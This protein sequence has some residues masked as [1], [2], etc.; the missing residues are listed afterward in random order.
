MNDHPPPNDPERDGAPPPDDDLLDAVGEVAR[1]DDATSPRREL[2]RR[3]VAGDATEEEIAALERE[4]ETSEDARRDLEAFRPLGPEFRERIVEGLPKK[5]AEVTPFPTLDASTPEP[6]RPVSRYWI[7]LAA[8]ALLAVAAGLWWLVGGVPGPSPDFGL[9]AYSPELSGYVSDQRSGDVEP[10]DLPTF[11]MGG[12]FRLVLRPEREAG[13]D[14]DFDLYLA[15]EDGVLQAWTVGYSR[16]AGGA[17][18]IEGALGEELPIE[19]GR[20]TLV[21]VW[22]A[23]G[24]LPEP[25]TLDD[26]ESV[27]A[28]AWRHLAVPFEVIPGEVAYG[29]LP[30]EVE[31]AGCFE[32]LPGPICIAYPELVIWARS[33]PD[34]EIIV[35]IDGEPV[36]DEGVPEDGGWRFR[37]PISEDN[38][39][40]QVDASRGARSGD[41]RLQF[42]HRHN[43]PLLPS[44]LH[45]AHT[46]AYAGDEAR[47]REHLDEY[48]DDSTESR[49]RGIAIGFLAHATS[50]AEER[51]DLLEE[52][53]D[54]HRAAGLPLRLAQDLGTLLHHYVRQRDFVSLRRQLEA[55]EAVEFRELPVRAEASFDYYRGILESDVGNYRDAYR[56]L[57]SAADRTR[58]LGLNRVALP[59]ETKLAEVLHHLGRGTEAAEQLRRVFETPGFDGL[60][61]C[62]RARIYTTRAWL[63]ILAG[64]RLGSPLPYLD[65]ASELASEGDCGDLTR[66]NL[67]LNRAL[68]LAGSGQAWEANRELVESEPLLHAGTT[69][70]RLW[71]SELEGR[72]SLADGRA[73]EALAHFRHMEELAATAFEPEGRWRAT[74]RQAEALDRLGSPE[75]AIELYARAAALLEDQS[76][77]VPLGEGRAAFVADRDASIGRY[78]D[79]LLRNG[80][81]KEALVV[82]RQSRSRAL[83]S[84]RRGH[85][86]A[87]LDGEAQARWD[88]HV[89]RYLA[90]RSEIEHSMQGEW[91]LTSFNRDQIQRQR[92]DRRSQALE[93]LDQ[94]F[95]VF[96]RKVDPNLSSPPPGEVLLA[97]H[98]LPGGW[99]GF[100]ALGSTTSFH[101]FDLEVD[102]EPGLRQW[103]DLLLEPFREILESGESLRILPYGRLRQ[104]DFH[105]LPWKEGALLDAKPVSY[106]LDL[107]PSPTPAAD[108][109]SLRRL[110]A[111]VVGDPRSNLPAARREAKV[112]ERALLDLSRSIDSLV[113]SAA[114][115]FA[116]LETLPRTDLLHFAGHG[117]AEGR[118]GSSLLLAEGSELSAGDVLSLVRAPTW[119]VLSSCEGARDTGTAAPGP[120]LAQAFLL[121]GSRGVVAAMRP[122]G[123]SGTQALFR[124]FYALDVPADS[125]GGPSLSAR[126]RRAQLDWRNE[127]PDADWA[128]FR[129]LVR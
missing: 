9:A 54:Y 94:A 87:Q 51:I 10:A 124:H 64:D 128:S 39:L 107:G 38:A 115:S 73:S 12:N 74:V 52:A 67:G 78:L 27:E 111:L 17:V 60:P 6:P 23:A 82:A 97:Y 70:H 50:S 46:L 92:S 96:G 122:V 103:S 7:P 76:L 65:L 100:A 119:V 101:R 106:G 15:D 29:E 112:V 30:L 33:E 1:D 44:W 16:S 68:A 88:L 81:V 77:Q 110:R 109:G 83:A 125:S 48:L 4:A 102:E 42:Q 62:S 53:T 116:L 5:Q 31:Y 41:F 117:V 40:L 14:T 120:G 8:A 19:P 59:A 63:S 58:R 28:G 57:R 104:I 21:F 36:E 32:V 24:E 13:A 22:G 108:S 123:D 34:A 11:E 80:R 18:R 118:L 99:V 43:S 105:A 3:L 72:L 25:S 20:W 91:T 121:A 89:G 98:P 95:Q 75:K 90:L 71:W 26:V 37:L 113:G 127:E 56:A 79:L 84:I 35:R 114:T 69:L 61:S 126:L 49:L 86:L 66:L 45:R 85:R 47:L 2:L 93:A 129:L 55:T